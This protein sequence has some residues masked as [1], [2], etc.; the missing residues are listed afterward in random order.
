MA[1]VSMDCPT[2]GCKKILMV[3][4]N[5]IGKP[6]VF[7]EFCGFQAVVRYAW[8]VKVWFGEEAP[9]EVPEEGKGSHAA[10]AA[11]AAASPPAK[12]AAEPKGKRRDLWDLK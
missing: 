5:K 6:T 9:A 12:P 2:P 7:C 11:A 3:K 8:A 4:K 10:P 1:K